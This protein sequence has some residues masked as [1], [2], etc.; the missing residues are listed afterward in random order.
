MK[1]FNY[2]GT[3]I[4]EKHYMVD[5]TKKIDQIIN[6][7]DDGLYFTISRPRQYGKTT[8]I[9][10]LKYRLE[11]A[12]IVIKISFEGLGDTFFETEKS[13]CEN[14]F[15]KLADNVVSNDEE[16]KKALKN[17]IGKNS[18][19]GEVSKAITKIIKQSDKK[20]ILFID[21]VDKASNYNIFLNFLGMLRAKYLKRSEG[22]DYTFHSVVLAGVH[23]IKNIKLK[24]RPESDTKFNSPWNIAID[25]KVDLSFS[26][27]EIATMLID[28]EKE[29]STGMDIKKIAEKLSEFTSGYPYL[30]SKL[31]CLIDTELEK[32]FTEN[33][34]IE[35][36]KI[37]LEDSSNSLFD[38]IIKN[39]E[40]NQEL[41]ELIKVIVLEDRRIPFSYTDP[42]ISLAAMY[43]IIKNNNKTAVIHN[44][45][46]ANLLYDHFIAKAIRER[47]TS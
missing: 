32:D 19:F 13:F 42:L 6:L 18:T 7:I 23:D 31:C 41:Y 11:K 14:I 26:S 22:E 9:N 12:N 45:I 40:N 27:D 16:F 25:F 21:E 2:T 17:E 8:T 37:I 29:N 30:V 34:I 4:P 46:F 39:I 24:I 15:D 43:G 38:D 3:C 5:T 44:V 33:G 35:A 10:Q 28:Y 47:S 1:R 20:V 36:I